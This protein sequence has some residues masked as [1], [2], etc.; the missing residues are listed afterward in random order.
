MIISNSS[1][2]T[3]CLGENIYFIE[4]IQPMPSL[5]FRA[6]TANNIPLY[7]LP[8]K[9]VKKLLHTDLLRPRHS[10]PHKAPSLPHGLQYCRRISHRF[11]PRPDDADDDGD[12]DEAAPNDPVDDQK[13]HSRDNG[14]S[15]LHNH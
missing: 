1:C 9:R 6:S 3:I 15:E 4:I 11:G 7:V 8:N 14:P 2:Y 10:L 13:S 5:Q 12:C